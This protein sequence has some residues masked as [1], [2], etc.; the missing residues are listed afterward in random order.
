MVGPRA[1]FDRF[2]DEG[3]RDLENAFAITRPQSSSEVCC[4]KVS[5]SDAAMRLSG[6]HLHCYPERD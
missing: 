6:R 5:N 4:N 1:V 2:V 3:K